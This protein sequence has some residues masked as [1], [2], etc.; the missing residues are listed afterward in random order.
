MTYGWGLGQVVPLM[1][2]KRRESVV[3]LMSDVAI[4]IC[5]LATVEKEIAASL[6]HP[7]GGLIPRNDKVE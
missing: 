3:R 7:S 4:S 1:S 6:D 2:F 5:F